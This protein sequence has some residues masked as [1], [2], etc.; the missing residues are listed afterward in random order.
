MGS[1]Y[2]LAAKLP[3][4]SGNIVLIFVWREK[5]Q[6]SDQPFTS[7]QVS[8]SLQR[9][10]PLQLPVPGRTL[11]SSASEAGAEK[12]QGHLFEDVLIRP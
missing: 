7:L 4:S 1:F 12:A 2:A 5:A 3:T 6:A 9:D 8:Q 10:K 11:S